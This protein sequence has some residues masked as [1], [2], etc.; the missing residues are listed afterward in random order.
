MT[1]QKKLE[2]HHLGKGKSST[3]PREMGGSILFSEVYPPRPPEDKHIHSLKTNGWN[4]NFPFQ[5]GPFCD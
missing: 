1:S 3:T 4:C 5:Y 2:H